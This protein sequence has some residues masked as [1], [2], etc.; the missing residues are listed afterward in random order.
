MTRNHSELQRNIGPIKLAPGVMPSQV[1]IFMFVVVCALCINIFMPMMQ[2]FVFSEMLQVAKTDQGRLAGSLL[3]TQQIA[4]LIFFGFAG[5][6]AD[7]LGRKTVLAAAILGYA[8]CLIAYPLAGGLVALFMLQFFF[9]VMSTGHIAGTAS[10]VADY[11][12]NQSRGKFVAMNLLVQA[13]VSGVLVG[14]VGARLPGWLVNSGIEIQAAGRYTFW[15]V[16]TL[17]IMAAGIAWWFLD[18]PPRLGNLNPSPP[19]SDSGPKQF[20]EN[21]KRVIAHGRKNARFGLVMIMGL[22]IRSDYMVMLSFVSLWVI[23]SASSIGIPT[24]EALKTAG[25]LM[26]TFKIATASSQ[27]IFGF[28]A[29]RVNRSV[30]LIASLAMTGISLSSAILITDVFGIWMYLLVAFIGATESAL[31]VCGQ[32]ILGE[33]A[34]VDLRGS[35]LGIFYF[36]GTLGVVVMSVV[37]GFLFDRIG[38]AAPFVLI[39]MLNL[40]FAALGFFLI[41]RRKND[42]NDMAVGLANGNRQ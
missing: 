26:L 13:A 31:I 8:V 7:H 14:L 17:G 16:A 5:S 25:M 12:D 21:L 3:T 11:P 40:G 36:S 2:A 1:F 22:V 38:Y 41:I 28:V 30:M 18:N 33:E 9:G 19:K 15:A 27:L 39:G 20:L 10:M 29:D 34:P 37:A 32:A 35:A 4:A 42:N 24:V 23:N 6:L